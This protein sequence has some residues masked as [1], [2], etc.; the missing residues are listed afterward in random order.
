MW[1]NQ[2]FHL[3]NN[4]IVWVFWFV[5]PWSWGSKAIWIRTPLTELLHWVGRKIADLLHSR[6]NC[7]KLLRRPA[8]VLGDAQIRFVGEGDGEPFLSSSSNL[9]SFLIIPASPSQ[10]KPQLDK[11][12]WLTMWPPFSLPFTPRPKFHSFLTEAR[13]RPELHFTPIH[14]R[15]RPCFLSIG[16]SFLWQRSCIG[17]FP[18][19]QYLIAWNPTL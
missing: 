6:G 8:K 4:H 12:G 15:E 5:L 7:C 9:K 11:Q 1:A 14:T 17:F 18:E 10:C 3:E 16:S 13:S 2:S 19:I